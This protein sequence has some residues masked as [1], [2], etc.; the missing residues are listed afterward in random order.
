[1]VVAVWSDPH[2]ATKD[3]HHVAEPTV[4]PLWDLLYQYR[5]NAAI[6]LNGHKHNYERFSKQ[7]NNGNSASNGIVEVVTGTGGNGHYIFSTPIAPNSVKRNDTDWG[8]T[9]LTLN[10]SSVQIRFISSAAGFPEK[11]NVTISLTP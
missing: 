2:F 11:D 7:D 10:A 6:V 1:M 5:A 3:D 4:K 8:V 9:E